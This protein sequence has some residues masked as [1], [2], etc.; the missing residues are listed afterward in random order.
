MR[1]INATS[2]AALTDNDGNEG[3]E[4]DEAKSGKCGKQLVVADCIA[5][6]VH[7][8]ELLSKVAEWTNTTSRCMRGNMLNE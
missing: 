7:N 1:T 3:N 2:A 8:I 5:S 4:G 6:I